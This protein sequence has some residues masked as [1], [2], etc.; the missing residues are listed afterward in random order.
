MINDPQNEAVK[1]ELIA[2][3]HTMRSIEECEMESKSSSKNRDTA[4]KKPYKK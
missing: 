3:I 4:V 2:F 1:G